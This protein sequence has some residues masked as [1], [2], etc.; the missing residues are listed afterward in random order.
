MLRSWKAIASAVAMLALGTAWSLAAGAAV[1]ED[2]TQIL[3]PQTPMPIPVSLPSL[4]SGA[5]AYDV[6]PQ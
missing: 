3:M 1:A 6:L 5:T 2:D 4:I